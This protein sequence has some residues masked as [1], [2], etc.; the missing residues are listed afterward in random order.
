MTDDAANRDALGNPKHTAGALY[1]MVKPISA[2]S[3]PVGQFNHSRI[4]VRGNHVEHWLNGIKVVE[5]ALDSDQARAG[6]EKRWAAS[7][8]VAALLSGQPVKDCPIS[9]QNHSDEAWFR[10]IK[11]RPL[12]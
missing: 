10:N 12:K 6:I 2:A 9:L 11:I 4:L 7:P 3:L 1:D 8:H 5:S